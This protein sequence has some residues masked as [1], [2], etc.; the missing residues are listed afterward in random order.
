MKKLT[1]EEIAQRLQE[2]FGDSISEL[3]E[4]YGMMAVTVSREAIFDFMKFLKEDSELNYHYLTDLTGV[5]YPEQEGK[6]VGVVYHLHNMVANT[7]LRVK[8]FFP[9]DDTTV[10]SMTPL[11]AGANWMERETYD[12]FGINF[13]GHPDLRRILNVDEMDYFPMLKQ[14]PLEEQTREDKND[15]MFGR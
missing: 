2:Q 8:T 1:H 9:A 14:Y 7:R 5:H 3:V 10:P 6:E 12:F 15:R 4:T 13:E 11:W